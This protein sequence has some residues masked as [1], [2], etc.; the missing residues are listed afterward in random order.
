MKSPPVKYASAESASSSRP[1][2]RAAVHRKEIGASVAESTTTLTAVSVAALAGAAP[3]DVEPEIHRVDPES[4]S[5]RRL[6]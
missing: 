3:M 5:T 1:S 2:I 6:L 4:G